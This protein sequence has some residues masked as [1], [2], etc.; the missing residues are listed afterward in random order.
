MYNKLT[1]QHY[2]NMIVEYVNA[3]HGYFMRTKYKQ[4]TEEDV[5]NYCLRNTEYLDSN[6][7]T[8]ID[9][10][11]KNVLATLT[12]AGC[13]SLCGKIYRTE[14]LVPDDRNL[15]VF[16]DVPEMGKLSSEQMQRLNSIDV[17]LADDPTAKFCGQ[18]DEDI[19]SK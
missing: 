2:C 16:D 5:Y 6:D 14:N 8:E 7:R 19:L 12:R 1:P 15:F 13:L 17:S 4:F 11:V 3:R 9:K 18:E 10:L